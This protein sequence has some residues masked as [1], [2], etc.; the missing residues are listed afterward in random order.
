[1]EYSYGGGFV[2]ENYFVFVTFFVGKIFN[3]F[4][5]FLICSLDELVSIS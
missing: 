2:T 4:F 1:M 3:L 5:I